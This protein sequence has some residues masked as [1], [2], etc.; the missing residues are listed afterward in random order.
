MTLTAY[1]LQL[2]ED[3]ET[4]VIES[5]AGKSYT[6]DV[7]KCIYKALEDNVP[8]KKIGGILPYTVL[9]LTGQQLSHTPST[10][11]CAHMA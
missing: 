6:P 4:S 7:R 5:N 9:T 3:L 11:T 10:S 2:N 8:V 1:D